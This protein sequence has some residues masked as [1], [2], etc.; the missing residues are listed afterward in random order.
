MKKVLGVLALCVALGFAFSGC[1]STSGA[2]SGASALPWWCVD[3][4][5]YDTREADLNPGVKP[6]EIGMFG[7]GAGYEGDVR[8]RQISARIAAR[9][10][11]ASK[12]KAEVAN[13]AVAMGVGDELGIEKVDAVLVGSRVLDTYQAPDGRVFTV[14]FISNNDMKESAKEDPTLLSV[15]DEVIKKH[16]GE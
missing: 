3:G 16:V 5:V 14:V 6:A 4:K 2:S 8:S 10:A 9:T 13:A 15:V 11:L 1:A 7:V 12:I